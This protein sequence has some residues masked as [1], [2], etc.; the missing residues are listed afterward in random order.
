MTPEERALLRKTADLT[1]ENNEILLKLRRAQVWSRALRIAYW[2]LI[3]SASLGAYYLI[4]PYVEQLAEAYSGLQGT[5]EG[6]KE[7]SE[8]IPKIGDIVPF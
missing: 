1:K 8:S 4:Q 3:I 5:V 6:L 2:V 7:A